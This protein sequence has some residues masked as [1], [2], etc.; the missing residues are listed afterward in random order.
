MHSLQ[1][2]LSEL[3]DPQGGAVPGFVATILTFPLLKGKI[4]AMSE[5]G[6]GTITRQLATCLR[7]TFSLGIPTLDLKRLLCLAA[8]MGLVGS[9]R[10][11]YQRDGF[12]GAWSS[13]AMPPRAP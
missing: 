3:P 6:A 9:L 2:P 8:A 10:F 7:E 11:V 13:P 1:L 12:L 5:E 4:M